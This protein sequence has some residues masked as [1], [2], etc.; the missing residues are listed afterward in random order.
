MP[1]R[2]CARLSRSVCNRRMSKTQIFIQ[3]RY[4][5]FLLLIQRNTNISV[6]LILSIFTHTLTCAHARA[7]VPNAHIL[8]PRF[9][10]GS[11]QRGACR[12]LVAFGVIL[13]LLSLKLQLSS[14]PSVEVSRIDIP[15]VFCSSMKNIM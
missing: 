5:M 7:H 12:K 13:S 3:D 11:T 8:K 2:E 6:F 9:L 15:V 1:E 4:I 14:L 10:I